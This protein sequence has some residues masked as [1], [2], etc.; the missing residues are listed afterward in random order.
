[1][2]YKDLYQ[3]VKEWV[4][5]QMKPFTSVDLTKH[6]EGLNIYIFGTQLG[7]I[8]QDLSKENL[9]KQNGTIKLNNKRNKL[10]EHKVWL[11]LSYRLKQQKNASKDNKGLTLDL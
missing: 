3:L 1:M 7:K 2:T 9:V 8:F 5:Q 10:T 6:F 4:S 11:S